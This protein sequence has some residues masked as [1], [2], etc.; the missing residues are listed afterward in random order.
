MKSIL[1]FSIFISMTNFSLAETIKCSGRDSDGK[2]IKLTI[3]PAFIL[4]IP[5]NASSIN[6]EVKKGMK[7]LISNLPVDLMRTHEGMIYQSGNRAQNLILNTNALSLDKLENFEATL[8]LFKSTPYKQYF[9]GLKCS[10]TG[11]FFR[12]PPSCETQNIEKVLVD[13]I[14]H[15]NLYNIAN[16]LSC[17]LDL[18]Y[19][20]KNGCTAV[21]H[22]ITKNCGH[23]QRSYERRFSTRELLQSLLEAGSNPDLTDNNGRTPIH[24]AALTSQTSSIT[25]LLSFKVEVDTKDRFGNTALMYS[26]EVGNVSAVRALLSAGANKHIKNLKGLTAADISVIQKNQYILNLLKLN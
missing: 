26:V 20:D 13:A 3:A 5:G 17:P 16:L 2:K 1:F 11:T 25:E 4:A 10:K 12:E 21:H 15:E 19:M 6:I 22:A 23:L 14:F 8:E 7:S 9:S 18:D 24:Y